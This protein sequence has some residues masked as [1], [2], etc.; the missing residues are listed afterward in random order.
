M[1]WD[2][3]SRRKATKRLIEEKLSIGL[4][5]ISRKIEVKDFVKNG[6][7]GMI[8]VRFYNCPYKAMDFTC[9]GRN[10]VPSFNNALSM[11]KHY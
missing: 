4:K 11:S 7:N 10:F 6:L 9:P 8:H 5:H 3:E 2:D 1:Y